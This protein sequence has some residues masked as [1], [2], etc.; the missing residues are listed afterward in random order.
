M[1]AQR[2]NYALAGTAL[3]NPMAA[4]Y[5]LDVIR[6]QKPGVGLA[7]VS[8][9]GAACAALAA[10]RERPL[11]AV[12]AGLAAAAG[13]A[14]AGLALDRYVA[15]LEQRDA[16]PAPPDARDLLL[17][18]AAVCAGV[19][20]A[21]AMVGRK[22]VEFAP[23][24]GKHG[25]Y[26]WISANP[27]PGARPSAWTGYLAHQLAIWGCIYA[28]QRSRPAYADGM[29]PLNW[30]TLA[31]NAGGVALHYAQ[32]RRYYDGLAL[33]VPE[34][35]SLSSAAF[36]LMVILAMDSPRRGLL[37]GLKQVKLPPEL[38]RFTRRYHGYI[39]SWAT[40]YTFWYHPIDPLPSHLTGLYHMLLLFMQSSLVYTR[41]HL[42]PRWTLA[43][44]MLAMP[45]AIITT[46]QKRS[47]F[48][49][50][51]VFGFTGMFVLAQ[52]HG[53]GLS[54][55]TR[56]GI[57]ALYGATAL[58]WYAS[59]RKLKRLPDVLRIPILEYGV[60]GILAALSLLIR[61]LRRR[62]ADEVIEV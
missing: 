49:P 1:G 29:R 13:A 55:Q 31:V 11:R 7:A 25:D 5:W 34:G 36:M 10:G 62:D 27:V 21:A 44:E 57:G 4:V 37:L 46:L 50:V 24:S 18:A 8:A 38:I 20:G 61:K 41:A 59:Q 22:E 52:M 58:T 14:L 28:A 47:G 30:I 45:H 2:S 19:V 54:K 15:W 23:F 32:T 42:D 60:V 12:G 26:R 6:G 16:P 17:P 9:A 51:F 56:L 48:A 43:L 35:S 53:L 40:V 39:F 33:D 3:F